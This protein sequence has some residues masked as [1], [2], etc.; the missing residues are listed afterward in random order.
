MYYK[1]PAPSPSWTPST[2]EDKKLEVKTDKVIERKNGKESGTNEPGE[3][4][5]RKAEK[6]GTERKKN[7]QQ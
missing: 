6:V 7:H 4:R 5:K 1:A 2:A 3:G